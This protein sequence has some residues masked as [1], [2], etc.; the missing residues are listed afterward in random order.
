MVTTHGFLPSSKIVHEIIEAILKGHPKNNDWE[1][2]H[3]FICALFHE[4]KQKDPDL[5]YDSG[6][7]IVF[8]ELCRLKLEDEFNKIR[9]RKLF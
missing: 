4:A 9:I 6:A 3:D 8:E 2:R 1:T 5:N 7:V